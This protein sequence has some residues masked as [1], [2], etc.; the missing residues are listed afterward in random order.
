L[1]P[2]LLILGRIIKKP[3]IV[4]TTSLGHMNT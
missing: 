4:S 3:N 2:R 1:R